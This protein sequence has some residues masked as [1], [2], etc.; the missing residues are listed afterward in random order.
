MH[1]F[2]DPDM[3]GFCIKPLDTEIQKAYSVPINIKLN[4]LQILHLILKPNTF[5]RRDAWRQ[6]NRIIICLTFNYEKRNKI[7]LFQLHNIEIT[8]TTER[9]LKYKNE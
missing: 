8:N 7:C 1:F 4:I 5:I 9:R 2:R 6:I 3:A